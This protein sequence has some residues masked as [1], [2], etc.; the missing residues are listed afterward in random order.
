MMEAVGHG[1][2][3]IKYIQVCIINSLCFF[4]KNNLIQLLKSSGFLAPASLQTY[5]N[6]QVRQH[7]KHWK[8]EFKKLRREKVIKF[9]MPNLQEK[10]EDLT[11]EEMR[12]RMKEKGVM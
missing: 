10:P 5:N 9:D 4:Y 1:R 11:T 7:S 6:T 12:S 3:C 8:P 2:Q